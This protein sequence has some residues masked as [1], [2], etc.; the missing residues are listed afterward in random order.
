MKKLLF[1]LLFVP[2][3]GLAQDNSWDLAYLKS[4]PDSLGKIIRMPEHKYFSTLY[5]FFEIGMK[6]Q[7]VY[8]IAS[9]SVYKK[10]F[11]EF[12]KDSVPV[13][14]F[15]KKELLV[16]VACPQCLAICQHEGW[17]HKPCHRNVCIYRETWY[18]RNRNLSTNN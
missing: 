17:D 13:I 15:S 7:Y 1:L 5:R 8:S 18:L 2:V 16:Y 9:D 11:A 10:V 12:L 6:S 3:F 14:D 4:R